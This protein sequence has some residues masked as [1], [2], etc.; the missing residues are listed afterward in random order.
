[1]YH[2]LPWIFQEML[3]AQGKSEAKDMRVIVEEFLFEARYK[4]LH[5]FNPWSTEIDYF[6][7]FKLN[8]NIIINLFNTYVDNLYVI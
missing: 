6:I 4:E 5:M 1:M 7:M 3:V 8:E 2:A